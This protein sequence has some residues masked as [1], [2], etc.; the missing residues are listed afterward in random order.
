MAD[1][2]LWPSAVFVFSALV[3]FSACK[4]TADSASG[5]AG[6]PAA[7]PT[8]TPL[9]PGSTAAVAP[10][11][12]HPFRMPSF[13]RTTVPFV[14]LA[15]TG[16]QGGAG[17]PHTEGTYASAARAGAAATHVDNAA[18][19]S[20]NKRPNY[21][22]QSHP[23][24]TELRRATEKQRKQFDITGGSNADTAGMP[25]SV[26]AAA[27]T[28]PRRHGEAAAISG[29]DSAEFP[30]FAVDAAACYEFA[31]ETLR[32]ITPNASAL[33][34]APCGAA[35]A[36]A[37]SP[38]LAPPAVIAAAPAA[39]S[40]SSQTDV[41][42][43]ASDV[44]QVRVAAANN[45]EQPVQA[46]H[47]PEAV[48]VTIPPRSVARSA[49]APASSSAAAPA[50]IP[51]AAS[52]GGIAGDI[53]ASVADIEALRLRIAELEATEADSRRQHDTKNQ[54]IAIKD[55]QIQML[56]AW[57]ALP[58]ALASLPRPHPALPPAL[59]P[60]LPHSSTSPSWR[61]KWPSWSRT[62]RR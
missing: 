36:P 7:N 29:Q 48:A 33:P 23:P 43:V 16:P 52:Q 32:R 61:P 1:R 17:V 62:A 57:C 47:P 24:T 44:A 15:A 51:V 55:A 13:L 41:D 49:D 10:G 34:A 27:P 35:A 4:M 18:A 46:V 12:L 56:Q 5:N 8:N 30:K 28:Q 50:P 21:P 22:A 25:L 6:A 45:A 38:T 60:A 53:S 20:V 40:S 3:S 9:I 42:M 39:A 2:S 59:G 54:Q 31:K 37:A 14:H 11:Q 19:V 58:L 26:P